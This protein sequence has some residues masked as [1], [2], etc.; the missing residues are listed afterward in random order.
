MG[1][2]VAA[3]L[4]LAGP[5]AAQDAEGGKSL[6]I[7]GGTVLTMVGE[8]IAEGTVVVT[9]GK[10]TSV[11]AD[12][13]VPEGATVIDATGKTVM[14]GLIDALSRL[15]IHPGELNDAGMAPQHQVLDGLDLF[16]KT[17]PQVLRH[18]VTTVHV[19]PGSRS[20]ISGQSAVVKVSA[21]PGSLV[22]VS[23][24]ATVR[25]QIGIPSGDNT[26]SLANLGNY[27]SLR[28]AL[29]GARGYI[30]KWEKYDRELAAYDRKT[31]KDK[32]DEDGEKKDN[33]DEGDDGEKKDDGDKADEQEPPAKPPPKPG[34]KP[35]RPAKPSKDPS[36][37]ALANVLKGELPLLIEAHRVVDILNALRLKDEFEIRLILLGCSEGHKIAGEIARRGVPVIVAPVSLSY[38]MP[39]KV[40][41]GEQSLSNAA[42]LAAAGIDVA[43]AVGGMDALHTKFVRASAA[44][45]AAN[46]L[47]RDAALRG[48]TSTAAELLGIADRVGSIAEGKDAD[49]II[50]AGDPLDVRAPVETVIVDGEVVF[51][52]GADE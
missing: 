6:A 19:A 1:P 40:K 27:T 4:I 16:Q 15:Y 9:D 18:G 37:E 33:G 26:S 32:E 35:K 34:E 43:L 47:S 10:I 21:V 13:E 50:I 3:V 39:S 17:A 2:V 31:G 30:L 46:G 22:T 48:V 28:E 42:A 23:E 38:V 44:V 7:Q 8:P 36:N 25:G 51:E 49:L 41:H 52:R 12:V 5:A 29:L 11:G 24:A 14:P 20:L 45:A